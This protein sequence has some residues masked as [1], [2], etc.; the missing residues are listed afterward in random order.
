MQPLYK[1]V[2]LDIIAIIISIKSGMY[3]YTVMV[4]I[5]NQLFG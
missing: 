3:N 2:K 1:L 4:V 5:R